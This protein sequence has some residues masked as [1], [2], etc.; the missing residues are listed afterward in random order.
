VSSVDWVQQTQNSKQPPSTT[1]TL[2][3]AEGGVTSLVA[4]VVSVTALPIA[5]LVLKSFASGAKR[6]NGFIKCRGLVERSAV[7]AIRNRGWG[8]ARG[9]S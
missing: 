6:A 7:T 5:V 9:R 4:S 3:G 8:D 2:V 1:R